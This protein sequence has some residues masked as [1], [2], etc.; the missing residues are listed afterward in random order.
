MLRVEDLASLKTPK[1]ML[2]VDVFRA[3]QVR[4]EDLVLSAPGSNKSHRAQT[5][6]RISMTEP[7]KRSPGK[8]GD[9]LS[10]SAVLEGAF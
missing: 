6:G 10:L 8:G 9:A 1:K 3:H 5:V 7:A 2:P 4:S